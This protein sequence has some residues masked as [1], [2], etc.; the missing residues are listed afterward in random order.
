MV[1]DYLQATGCPGSEF[2]AKNVF[3]F[4]DVSA[5][6]ESAYLALVASDLTCAGGSGTSVTALV[7]VRTASGQEGGENPLAYLRVDPNLSQ[8]VAQTVGA[9]RAITGFKQVGGQ[10]FAQGVEYG[11]DDANCCPSLKTTYKVSLKK[12]NVG[13]ADEPR[14]V[15]TWEFTS[16]KK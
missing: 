1:F 13:T 14:D 12:K 5:G 4:A 16:I 8:P 11:P 2:D 6:V 10:L 3:P 15:F 9:P 7:L